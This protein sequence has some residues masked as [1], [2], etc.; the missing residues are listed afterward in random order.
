MQRYVDDGRISGA[1]VAREAGFLHAEEEA[2]RATAEK[3]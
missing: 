3:Q 2:A 1:Y